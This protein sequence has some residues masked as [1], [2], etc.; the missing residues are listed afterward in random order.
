M[1]GSG[2][3]AADAE[4]SSALQRGMSAADGV[5]TKV[6]TSCAADP[7]GSVHRAWG[8]SLIFIIVYFSLSIVEGTSVVTLPAVVFGCT[9]LFLR[10]GS[11]DMP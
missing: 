2:A 10:S 7:R 1:G 8:V 11:A 4:S 3:A 5:L 9:L 6:F